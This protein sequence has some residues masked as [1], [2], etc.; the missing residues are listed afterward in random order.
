[1]P[2]DKPKIIKIGQVTADYGEK[3][4]NRVFALGILSVN[5]TFA[6]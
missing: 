3:R 1:M 6:I 2:L 5:G 4:Y